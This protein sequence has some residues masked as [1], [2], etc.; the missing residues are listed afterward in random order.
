MF[1]P[2]TGKI[3]Q[4][5]IPQH[6]RLFFLF[7]RYLPQRGINLIVQHLFAKTEVK[8]SQTVPFTYC[9]LTALTYN[10][11]M[12]KNNLKSIVHCLP[13]QG[14]PAPMR[15]SSQ[16]LAEPPDREEKL[17]P[18]LPPRIRIYKLHL[19]IQ[20]LKFQT[21]YRVFIILQ[22]LALICI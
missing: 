18:S 9:R 8:K 17:N 5:C 6:G 3:T 4:R 10:F 19:R 15:G 12:E 14:C 2:P 22:G 20:I 7:P 21:R 11:N 1:Y 13:F 16:Y